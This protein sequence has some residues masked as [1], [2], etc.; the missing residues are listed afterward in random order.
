V[1]FEAGLGTSGACWAAVQRLLDPRI[2]SYIYD[3]AGHGQSPESTASRSAA[4]MATELLETLQAANISPPYILVGHSY[5]GIIIRETLA[6]AGADA[7]AGMV[8]VDANQEKTHPQLRIPFPSIQSLCG[9]RNYFE[10]I[11]LLRDTALTPEEMARVGMDAGLPLTARSSQ[12]EAALL[13][14][15]SVALGEKH[16]LDACP[17]GMRPVTVIRG[18]AR[19]DFERLLA[20]AYESH[21]GTQEDL[22][23]IN[24][25]LTNRLDVFDLD[26]QKENLRLSKNGRFVQATNSGHGVMATEPDIVASEILAIWEAS[27]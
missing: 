24:D 20:A 9:E 5:G 25:F 11:G 7:I 6:A 23:E 2:R 13:I 21:S 14:E 10:I 3:R 4:S 22:D 17:L 1:I 8:F 15:S 27:L 16:Q 18:N 19:R 26:L 12:Q